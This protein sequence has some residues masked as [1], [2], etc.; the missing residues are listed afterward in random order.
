MLLFSDYV[1]KLPG[2]HINII[3]NRRVNEFISPGV[4]DF[5]AAKGFLK[6]RYAGPGMLWFTDRGNAAK[7]V[8]RTARIFGQLNGGPVQ[9]VGRHHIL[10]TLSG[11]A[12]EVGR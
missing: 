4:N 6:A 12:V 2:I 1:S 11:A 8:S 3:P 10:K 7:V 9:E 5:K